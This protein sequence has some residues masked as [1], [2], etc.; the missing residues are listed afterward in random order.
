[1]AGVCDVEALTKF[2]KL[3]R[4]QTRDIVK[5]GT[6]QE[7]HTVIRHYYHSTR[8]LKTPLPPTLLLPSLREKRTH[9]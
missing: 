8:T 5:R 6:Q 3:L 2:R 7:Q 1:M 9:L 4:D